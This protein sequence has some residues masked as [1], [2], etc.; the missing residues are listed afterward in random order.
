[1]TQKT[2]MKDEVGCKYKYT[3][4][5]ETVLVYKENNMYLKKCVRASNYR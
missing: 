3:C 5:I 1:M 4:T 2:R